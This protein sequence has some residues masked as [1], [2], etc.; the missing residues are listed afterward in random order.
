MSDEADC[1]TAPAPPGLLN[2]QKHNWSENPFLPKGWLL[3]PKKDLSQS[4]LQS[5]VTLQRHVRSRQL[6]KKMIF[7]MPKNKFLLLFSIAN[8]CNRY[9]SK[10]KKSALGCSFCILCFHTE[11]PEKA[12]LLKTSPLKN[13]SNGSQAWCSISQSVSYPSSVNNW[14]F[15]VAT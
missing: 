13:L 4:L 9:L 10:Y 2:R 11:R 5:L 7:I 8:I 12:L 1:R 15:S 3:K 6:N 14:R